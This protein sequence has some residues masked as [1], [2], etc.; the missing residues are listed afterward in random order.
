MINFGKYSVL[1]INV[2]CVDYD[3][4]VAQIS[5]AAE[6]RLPYAVS[7]LA[8][9]GVMTGFLVP[10]RKAV[11]WLRFGSSRWAACTMGVVRALW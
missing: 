7:A 5:A 10:A 9:H 11:E 4:S 3:Y 6:Q 8:V 2:H 1:G